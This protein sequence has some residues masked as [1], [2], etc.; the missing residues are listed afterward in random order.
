MLRATLITH[1]EP[2]GSG[3]TFR[4]KRSDVRRGGGLAPALGR[5]ESATAGAALDHV[6]AP[7][8]LGVAGRYRREQ[9]Y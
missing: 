9:H 5:D 1:T 4:T 2:L 6:V 3:N 8:D 7:G